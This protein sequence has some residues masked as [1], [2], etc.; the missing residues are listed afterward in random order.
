VWQAMPEGLTSFNDPEAGE[1]VLTFRARGRGTAWSKPV[2]LHLLV[3][4]HWYQTVWFWCLPVLFGVFSVIQATRYLAARRLRKELAESEQ[5]RALAEERQRIAQD[6]HD[7]IGAE[8]SG[9]LLLTR[10]SSKSGSLGAQD[11][12]NLADIEGTATR[13]AQ[14]IQDIVW[15]LDPKDDQLDV[16]LAYIQGDL[17][18]MA[19]IHGLQF[20]THAISGM[21]GTAFPSTQRR[22]LQL[23]MTE[24]LHNVVKH[25]QATTVR[26]ECA[27]EGTLVRLALI[28]DGKGFDP[29]LA[30]DRGHGLANLEARAVRLGGRLTYLPAVTRGTQACVVFHVSNGTKDH[31]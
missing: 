13:V 9:L 12:L 19:R 11:K 29:R 27:M 22:E 23:L 10:H 3:Q 31:P 17:E 15:S 2:V 25:A 28:D 18:D 30:R 5:Q 4:P 26:F 1:Q 24:L 8:M 14:K 20:T 16:S 21:P 7:D 6:M